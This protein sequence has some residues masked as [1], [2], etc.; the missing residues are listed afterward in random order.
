MNR[1]DESGLDYSNLINHIDTRFDRLEEKVDN[2]LERISKSEATIE[3][4]KGHLQTGII[5]FLAVCGFLATSL[6]HIITKGI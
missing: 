4:M 1:K 3:W 2:H 5:I 6:Y